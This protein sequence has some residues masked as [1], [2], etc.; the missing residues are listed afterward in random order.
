[1]ST[2]APAGE[3]RHRRPADPPPPW[4]P[5][6]WACTCD[7]EAIP[8]RLAPL[9]PLPALEFPTVGLRTPGRHRRP[10]LD[11]P[12]PPGTVSLEAYRARKQL[13]ALSTA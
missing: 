10:R 9:P 2:T 5:R 8:D 4:T 11:D 7:S 12:A 1:M 6:S 13:A 3:G